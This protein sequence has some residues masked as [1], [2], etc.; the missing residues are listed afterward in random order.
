MCCS[1]TRSKCS[2]LLRHGKF[3]LCMWY[4]RSK[5]QSIEFSYQLKLAHS[6]CLGSIFYWTGY[7]VCCC[8]TSDELPTEQNQ[9]ND[10]VIFDN[11][12][13]ICAWA[14]KPLKAQMHDHGCI[15][16]AAHGRFWGTSLAWRRS[17]L[18]TQHPRHVHLLSTSA[19]KTTLASYIF[20][21][22][23]HKRVCSYGSWCMRRFTQIHILHAKKQE[24]AIFR[25]DN[26]S[27]TIWKIGIGP[28]RLGLRCT[29]AKKWGQNDFLVILAP[30]FFE[31]LSLTNA[32]RQHAQAFL[33]L[34]LSCS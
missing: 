4:K 32:A 21:L 34:D 11:Y 15:G 6:I 9:E 13:K 31:R 25:A 24:A 1:W 26:Q 3:V 20:L 27:M 28:K 10:L 7:A 30:I 33:I 16:I 29:I 22:L 23:Q 12:S 8:V 19:T 2:N 14:L 18:P 17:A 5:K